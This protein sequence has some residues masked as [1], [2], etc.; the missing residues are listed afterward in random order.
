MPSEV[1][2]Y[3][4]NLAWAGQGYELFEIGGT[5]HVPILQCRA[6]VLLPAQILPCGRLRVESVAGGLVVTSPCRGSTVLIEASPVAPGGNVDVATRSGETLISFVRYNPSGRLSL[7]QTTGLPG[8]TLAATGIEMT[9]LA[10]KLLA[11][12]A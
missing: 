11:P 5:A 3:P 6:E 7:A 8:S 2:G 9:D 4:G 1:L 12:C 10:F